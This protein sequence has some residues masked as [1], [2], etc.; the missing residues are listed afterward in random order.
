MCWVLPGFQS[1]AL[2]SASQGLTIQA[3]EKFNMVMCVWFILDLR[4][5]DLKAIKSPCFLASL[6]L[7]ALALAQLY[8]LSRLLL[9]S[10]SLILTF[11][12][13]K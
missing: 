6:F 7:T 10:S 8:N 12:C 11:R 3:L 5:F 13:L 9:S 2:G 1:S 4:D